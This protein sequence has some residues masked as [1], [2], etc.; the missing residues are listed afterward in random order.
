MRCCL[1]T[2]SRE[3]LKPS[4]FSE[5]DILTRRLFSLEKK[6]E[7]RKAQFNKHKIYFPVTAN[8][9]DNAWE[10][11]EVFTN[12]YKEEETRHVFNKSITLLNMF[13]DADF[14]PPKSK[15]HINFYFRILKYTSD[16]RSLEMLHR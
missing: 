14:F 16:N 1:V 5:A 12:L 6:S 10:N 11:T 9:G 15:L 7:S 4:Q 3:A 13:F 8:H 2:L